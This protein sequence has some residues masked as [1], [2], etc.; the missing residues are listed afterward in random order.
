MHAWIV[1]CIVLPEQD[2]LQDYFNHHIEHEL[3]ALSLVAAFVA[4]V[5]M[6]SGEAICA[7]AGGGHAHAHA[8]SHE[9]KKALAVIKAMKKHD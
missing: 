8:H 3:H 4:C 5:A 9:D 1:L 6:M 2:Y 7:A